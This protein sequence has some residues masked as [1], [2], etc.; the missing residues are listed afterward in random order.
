MARTPG[1]ES[2]TKTEATCPGK[3][4]SSAVAASE[5]KAAAEKQRFSMASTRSRRPAPQL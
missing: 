1:S 2:E 4:Y 3:A 5:R